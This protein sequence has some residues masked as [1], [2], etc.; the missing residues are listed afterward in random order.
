MFMRSEFTV[1]VIEEQPFNG[2]LFL[3]LTVSATD[4]D[5]EAVNGAIS[6]SISD[7]KFIM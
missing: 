3:P 2:M 7:G 5:D 1:E 4:P 6:Y